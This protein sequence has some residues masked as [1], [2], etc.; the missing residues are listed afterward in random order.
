MP[1]A[2]PPPLRKDGGMALVAE[3]QA[4]DALAAATPHELC[5]AASLR[6]LHAVLADAGARATA[7]TW[8][9]AASCA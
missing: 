8:A 5:A 3:A 6:A 2:P 4:L 9:L 1:K 7:T